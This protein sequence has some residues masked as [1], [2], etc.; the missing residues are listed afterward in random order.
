MTAQLQV[1]KAPA[2]SSARIGSQWKCSSC[3]TA[4]GPQSVVQGTGIILEGKL[5]CVDCVKGGKKRTASA[6]IN[7]NVIIGAVIAFAGVLGGVAIFIPGQVLLTILVIGVVLCLTGLLGFTMSRVVRLGTFAVGL[8]AVVFSGWG[9]K[10]LQD[11]E[12]AKVSESTAVVEAKEI[13]KELSTDHVIEA[14]HTIGEIQTRALKSGAGMISAADQK[15]VERLTDQI[16]AWTRKNFGELSKPEHGALFRLMGEFGSVTTSGARKFRAFKI[17]DGAVS[18]TVAV[19]PPDTQ[20]LGGETTEDRTRPRFRG[21]PYTGTPAIDRVASMAMFLTRNVEKVDSMEFTLVVAMPGGEVKDYR[22]IKLNSEALA[23]MNGG[24]DPDLF[25][26]LL[27][28]VAAA[29]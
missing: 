10:V 17:S 6:D 4:L 9:I 27:E 20:P 7:W 15:H 29:K 5:I 18:L 26:K 8:T 2:S 25:R 16:E 19:D 22:T 12:R 11:R 3:G 23:S 24:G 28:D 1:G 21:S 14:R 13:E